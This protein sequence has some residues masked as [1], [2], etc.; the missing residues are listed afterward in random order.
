[1]QLAASIRRGSYTGIT[2]L[3]KTPYST[4][5]SISALYAICPGKEGRENKQIN[6]VFYIFSNSSQYQSCLV[7]QKL[8]IHTMKRKTDLIPTVFLTSWLLNFLKI[9]LLLCFQKQKSSQFS[10]LPCTSH[11]FL[12]F[13]RRHLFNY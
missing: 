1:M 5:A 11:Y 8:T 2:R 10:Y 13:S 12:H 9:P 4:V 6:T 3:L 7:F